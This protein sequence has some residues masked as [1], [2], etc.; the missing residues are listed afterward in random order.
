MAGAP[1]AR[2]SAAAARLRRT[3]GLPFA[4]PPPEASHAARFSGCSP[5]T[6]Q[7]CG[8]V[9]WL[10][11]APVRAQARLQRNMQVRQSAL[12]QEARSS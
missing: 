2:P 6:A 4:R 3:A 1:P 10:N 5:C 9:L 8:S 11:A 7:C 12:R